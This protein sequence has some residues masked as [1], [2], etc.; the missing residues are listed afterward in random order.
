MFPTFN[1]NKNNKEID[2]DD[3]SYEIEEGLYWVDGYSDSYNLW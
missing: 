3:D 1:E 2:I